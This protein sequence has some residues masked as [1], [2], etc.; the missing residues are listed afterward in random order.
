MAVHRPFIG[1]S[2]AIHRP[3]IGRSSA[4]HRPFIGRLA[5]SEIGRILVRLRISAHS[6]ASLTQGLAQGRLLARNPEMGRIL[7]LDILRPNFIQSDILRPI[8]AGIILRPN[9]LRR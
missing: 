5:R 2:S 6:D 7:V 3:F 8:S 4:V 9:S 1:H